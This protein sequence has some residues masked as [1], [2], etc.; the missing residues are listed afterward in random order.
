LTGLP[1]SPFIYPITDRRLAGNRPVGE[2]VSALCRGGARLIQLREKGL[3]TKEYRELAIEAVQAASEWDAALLINDR[4]DVALY[5]GAAGVHLGDDE[6]PP[7]AARK[8]LG[9]GKIIGVSCHSLEDVR[10]AVEGPID[11]FAVGPVYATDTKILRY[12]VVDLDLVRATR[13]I[14][15]KPMVAIGGISRESAAEAISAGADGVAVIS[16]LMAA[17]GIEK[18][19][20]ELTASLKAD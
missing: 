1:S 4:V 12:P 11:Y 2:I 6:L 9:E 16:A 18:L 20:R 8:V 10:E 17:T 3:T 15:D 7:A 19:T 13:E 5:S 14:T